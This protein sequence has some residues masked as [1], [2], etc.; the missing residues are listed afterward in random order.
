MEELEDLHYISAN[1]KPARGTQ[2]YRHMT[3]SFHDNSVLRLGDFLLHI[4]LL[5]TNKGF[6]MS[7]QVVGFL[8]QTT[9]KEGT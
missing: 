6:A 8:K 4:S 9:T 2:C 3:Y 1:M 7:T 5:T